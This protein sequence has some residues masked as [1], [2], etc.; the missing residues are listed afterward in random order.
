MNTSSAHAR[1]V[2]ER[3]SGKR[4]NPG[5]DS[6]AASLVAVLVLGVIAYALNASMITPALP[7]MAHELGTSVKDIAQVSSLF[8]LAGAVAGVVFSRFS[9][10]TGRKRM[11]L[12]VL[13]AT[14]VGTILCVFA[15]NLPTLL[16]GRVLQGASSAAFQLAYVILNERLSAKVFGTALGVI[17]S[18]NGGVGGL[19][20]YLGGRLSDTLGYRSIFVVIL[21]V[22][23]AAIGC[24]ALFLPDTDRPATSGHMDWW[25]SA[26]L[27]IGL[28]CVT[29]FVSYGSS[30]GWTAPTT[31]G[32]LVGTVLS[33]VAFVLVERRTTTPLIAV[34]HLRSRQVWP[35]VATTITVLAG[36]F[37]VI[38]FTV[39]ILSQ[40][41]DIGFGLSASRSALLYLAPAAVIGVFAA[42][43]AGWLAGKAGWIKI[44]RIGLVLTIVPLVVIALYPTNR[45]SVFAAI[46]ALGV[47]YNGLVLTTV[48]GLGVIQSPEEAPA[49][50]PGLNGAAFGIGAGLGIGI[51][52]PFA[53]Q[54]TVS[55]FTTSLWISC[56]ITALAL[57]ASFC[58]K[59]RES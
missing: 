36:V 6:K 18:I 40:N 24:V 43:A 56:G 1:W 55:G 26:A 21:L 46:A 38:N 28:I 34:R 47:V 49:A 57:A 8:F 5:A 54:G 13:A 35:V 32:Y 11:L 42:P 15:P 16:A 9:D 45:W 41:S 33:F 22:C 52:A 10:F 58:I 17:T 7:D 44:L 59:P 48:N 2:D 23:I 4:A 25:G 29:Y 3:K 30:D 31:L 51:V 39:V 37:S 14:S 20:G 12:A 19:D 50:L 53:A 27:S